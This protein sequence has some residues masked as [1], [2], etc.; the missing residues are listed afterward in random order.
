METQYKI[1]SDYGSCKELSEIQQIVKQELGGDSLQWT[2]GKAYLASELLVRPFMILLGMIFDLQTF[3]GIKCIFFNPCIPAIVAKAV[4]S[5]GGLCVGLLAQYC[6]K[7]NPIPLPLIAYAGN[8]VWNCFIVIAIQISDALRS[9]HIVS[10]MDT[11][12]VTGTEVA[13]QLGT[14]ILCISVVWRPW[15][16]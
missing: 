10:S 9:R 7:F 13:L 8:L 3:K 14:L 5:K 16:F 6:H 11:T 4:F 15:S 12:P 2:I 1:K